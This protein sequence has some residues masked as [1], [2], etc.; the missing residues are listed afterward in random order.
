MEP[1]KW[2][3]TPVRPFPFSPVQSARKFSAVFGVTSLAS[4]N[5]MRFGA[6]LPIATSKN[7]FE[8]LDTRTDEQERQ[9]RTTSS[10]PVSVSSVAGASQSVVVSLLLVLSG[11]T[12]PRR[13]WPPVPP[14][15]D[16]RWPCARRRQ[17][18]GRRR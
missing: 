1:L 13:R 16:A 3:G 5:V 18:S 7:T 8:R 9:D 14:R 6:A 4:S 11:L 17:T 10:T 2:S 15:S 12:L